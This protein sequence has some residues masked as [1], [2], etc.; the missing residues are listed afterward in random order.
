[1]V[2]NLLLDCVLITVNDI[3]STF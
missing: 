1:M 3:K 2:I